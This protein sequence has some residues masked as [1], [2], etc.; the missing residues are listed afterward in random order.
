MKK[1]TIRN[2]F[3]VFFLSG[4]VVGAVVG[5]YTPKTTIIKAM[6]KSETFQPAVY[7]VPKKLG[8]L[9]SD[10][11]YFKYSILQMTDTGSV[12]LMRLDD[13]IPMGMH[14]KENRFVFVYKG[15]ARGMIG[16]SAAAI[17]PGQLIVIP[18]GT[19]YSFEKTGDSPVELLVFSTPPFRNNE[20]VYLGTG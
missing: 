7:D 20:T 10:G 9:D 12:A 6:Q 17:A 18:A 4:L 1:K 8:Q 11:I 15:K 14:Q 3:I 13:R 5:F 19:A 16:E 2:F